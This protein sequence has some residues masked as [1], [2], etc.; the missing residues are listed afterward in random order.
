MIRAYMRASTVEQDA[1]R[2]SQML[3]DFA[4]QHGQQIA[5]TYTENA[6]GSTKDRPELKRLLADALKGDIVLVESVDRLTRLSVDDW[7][8]LRH[9]IEQ[10]GLRIVSLDLPTSHA[11]M[12]E[13]KQDE[14]TN[15]ML[16]AVNRMMTDVMA[17][18]ARKDYEQRKQRQAQGI[19][20]AKSEGRYK[21]R[22]IDHDKHH[23]IATLLGRGLSIR[24]TA[25]LVGCSP[26]TVQKTK[27]M[28]A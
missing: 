15:R 22:P 1:K 19:Q 14:F 26:M 23:K 21:G 6:S 10:K 24:E 5:A 25:R 28:I 13:T 20:K 7:E 9:E 17:A 2:A 3:Q 11:A 12:T 18:V 4:K 27:A 8:A 16:D